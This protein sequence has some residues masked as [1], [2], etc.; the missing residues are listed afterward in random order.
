MAD[1]G[2]RDPGE[3]E[4]QV[5]AAAEADANAV[6]DAE[7]DPEDVKPQP[8]AESIPVPTRDKGSGEFPSGVEATAAKLASGDEREIPERPES[9][10]T[11]T[12]IPQVIDQGPGEPADP[13]SQDIVSI[14]ETAGE[15]PD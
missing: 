4:D 2:Q 13:Q 7:P 12:R 11:K 1:Q 9:G 8:E 10:A 6:T 14:T 5:V 3:A 15:E